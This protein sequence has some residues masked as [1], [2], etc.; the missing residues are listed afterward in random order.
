MTDRYIEKSFLVLLFFSLLLH[1]GA[2]MLLYYLPAKAPQPPKEPV[3][4]DLQ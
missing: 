2:G 1:V 4:I 3:F